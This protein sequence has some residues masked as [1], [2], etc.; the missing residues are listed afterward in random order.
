MNDKSTEVVKIEEKEVPN[1]TQ[2][3]TVL[4]VELASALSRACFAR[5]RRDPSPG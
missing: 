1:K 4:I 2:R 5:T 3:I